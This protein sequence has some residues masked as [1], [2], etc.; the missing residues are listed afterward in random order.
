MVGFRHDTGHRSGSSWV[1]CGS[2]SRLICAA[3]RALQNSPSGS[4]P[5]ILHKQRRVRNPG[6]SVSE[7][8]GVD[9]SMA[10]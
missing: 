3:A 2:A 7:F 8:A 9:H 4:L 6:V 1:C 10:Q 5:R